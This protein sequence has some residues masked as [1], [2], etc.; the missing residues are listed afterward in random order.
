MGNEPRRDRERRAHEQEIIAA[1]ATVFGAK[2][3]DGASMDEIALAAEFTKRTVYLYFDTK[4]DLFFAAALRAFRTLHVALK[5]AA[6]EGAS[7]YERLQGGCRAY[8]RFS[9]DDPGNMRLI[10]EV[11][12]VKKKAGENSPMLKELLKFDDELFRWVAQ[13]LSEGKEDGS[14]RSDLDSLKATF[15][16]IFMMTGF[17]NQLSTTGTTFL[18]HFALSPQEFSEYSMELLFSS[19]RR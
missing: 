17:F 5:D 9:R 11:G 14:I 19:L 6:K 15:S 18:E 10:N 2:G 13:G 8:Y 16:V 7:G 4:E 3:F 12:L 1:A